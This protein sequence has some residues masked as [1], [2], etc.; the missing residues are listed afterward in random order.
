MGFDRW[1]P[2]CS[3]P[4]WSA[5]WPGEASGISVATISAARHG[6]PV[7]NSTLCRIAD[8]LRLAPVI[9]G[10][11]ELLGPAD[12]LPANGHISGG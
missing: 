8:A 9:Q 11:D 5:N 1:R 12:G 6:R 10:V 7:A 4:G 2:E 3:R